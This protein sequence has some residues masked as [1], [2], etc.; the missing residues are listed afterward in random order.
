[1]ASNRLTV[2]MLSAFVLCS[3]QTRDEVHLNVVAPGHFHAALLQKNMIPGVSSEVNVYAPQGEELDSYIKSI[4]QYNTRMDNPTRWV[5]KLHTGSDFMEQMP[6][7]ESHGSVVVLAGN[8][9][10][11]TEY[12][13]A[14]IDKG[15][16][17]LSDKPLAIN[18]EDYDLLKESFREAK[19]R[20]VVIYDL[21]TERYDILNQIVRT[22]L[23]CPHFGGLAADGGDLSVSM[24]STHH[25]YKEVSGVPLTRPQWYYDVRC[26]GEGIAD[27]TTHLI[28]LVFWQCFPSQSIY[29]SNVTMES[30]SHYP[31]LIS[32]EQYSKSTGAQDFPEYLK[33][34]EKDGS[35]PVYSNGRMAFSVRGV[36]V[37]MEVVWNWM[38]QS[39]SGDTFEAVYASP[40]TRIIVRQD[41]ST[42]FSKEIFL[43][44]AD[45]CLLNELQKAYEGLAYEQS[46]NGV[47]HVVIP[48][49]SRVGHEDHF[50]CVAR[51]FLEYVSDPAKLPEWENI[52]TLTKYYITT[53]AVDM[54]LRK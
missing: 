1:M 41:A 48:S 11:K 13:K 32:R 7:A 29:T 54:A 4:D 39:G 12:I 49:D 14:A 37:D 42:G 26:Q 40:K 27:V 24:K 36:P 25:F 44:N 28:D 3:C 9:R 23:N 17:V 6:Q 47:I 22:A 51:N 31:T 20:G 21:M 43:E 53:Q 38:P 33:D 34:I 30:A 18:N 50:N 19:D 2:A 10:D 46:G 45:E 15:Y 52:N 5:E 35:I 16:N 8:N